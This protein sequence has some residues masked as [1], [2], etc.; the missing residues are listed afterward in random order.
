MKKKLLGVTTSCV[1]SGGRKAQDVQR[2]SGLIQ[3]DIDDIDVKDSGSIKN[4][5][6][7]DKYTFAK[8]LSPSGK[9]KAI[10]RIEPSVESH[11]K[12]FNDI[13]SYLK[14]TYNIVCDPS[15]KDVNRLMFVS[16]DPGIYIN[17]ECA[18]FNLSKS[19]EQNSEK[20][21]ID[22][23]KYTHV[24]LNA[25]EVIRMIVARQI[26]ITKTQN[27]WVKI[28]YSLIEI[29]GSNCRE[30]IH[31]ISRFYSGY[32]YEETESKIEACFKSK[33]SGITQDTFFYLRRKM[34]F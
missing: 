15:V 5:L 23:T 14:R 7:T 21:E 8:F 28:I 19:S 34:G 24:H 25:L 30:H 18:I 26:D 12:S 10:F 9:V 16:W 20:Q 2:H 4:Q 13:V 11:K 3:I 31:T 22:V 32:S 17:Q 27:D 33:G 29:F 1:V 6:S